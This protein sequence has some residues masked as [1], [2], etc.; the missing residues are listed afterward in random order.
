MGCGNR[1]GKTNFGKGLTNCSKIILL[2][3]GQISAKNINKG[4][5]TSAGPTRSGYISPI[6]IGGRGARPIASSN[7]GFM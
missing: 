2:Y 4:G 7:L 3:K 5:Q 1:F 6:N